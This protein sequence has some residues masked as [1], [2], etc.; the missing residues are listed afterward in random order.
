MIV[1]IDYKL[2]HHF[3]QRENQPV[4]ETTATGQETNMKRSMALGL[5]ACAVAGF[6]LIGLTAPVTPAGAK[7]PV[8]VDPAVLAVGERAFAQC[9]GCHS[10][11]ADGRDGVGP[12]LYGVYGTKAGSHSATFKY[13]AAMKASGLTWDE[14]GLDTFLTGPSKAVPGT[15]MPYRGLADPATRKAL[16][17]YIRVTSSAK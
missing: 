8:P 9:K 2:C 11:A 5:V 12:N 4:A 17:A 7:A 13:S 15:K 1:E 3:L 16:I 14:A 10:I 6:T